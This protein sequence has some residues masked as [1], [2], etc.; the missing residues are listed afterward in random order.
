MFANTNIIHTIS[1]GRDAEPVGARQPKRQQHVT[2]C[3]FVE[4]DGSQ[5]DNKS[6]LGVLAADCERNWSCGARGLGAQIHRA[7]G[8]ASINIEFRLSRETIASITTWRVLVA[9][10]RELGIDRPRGTRCDHATR[11]LSSPCLQK[12]FADGITPRPSPQ[13]DGLL[14]LSLDCQV[15]DCFVSPLSPPVC[16]GV[17][18]P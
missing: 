3:S 10:H 12:V 16:R 13:R 1:T 18:S 9:T 5:D 6:L 15:S 2:L 11:S 7:A 17:S 4:F 14:V 8:A